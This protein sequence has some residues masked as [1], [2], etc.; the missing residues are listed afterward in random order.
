M[1]ARR[2]VVLVLSFAV[3]LPA[4]AVAQDPVLIHPSNYEV[5]IENE[6]VHVMDFRLRSRLTGFAFP[7]SSVGRAGDC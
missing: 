1:S 3:V 7:S 2:M 6:Q 5:L 4:L